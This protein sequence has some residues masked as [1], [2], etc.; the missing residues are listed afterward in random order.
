M[1]NPSGGFLVKTLLAFLG[2]ALAIEGLGSLVFP[3]AQRAFFH[4]TP[5]G[6]FYHLVKTL[7]AFLGW[8]LA[9]GGLGSLVFPKA[10][11]AFYHKT[12]GRVFYKPIFLFTHYLLFQGDI[13]PVFG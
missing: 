11:R 5:G 8:A 2:W 3:K 12:R 9:I 1:E 7:L 4:K 10:Q 6:V 13:H